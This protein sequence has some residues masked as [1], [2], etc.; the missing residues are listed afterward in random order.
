MAVGSGSQKQ[1]F[2]MALM[3]PPITSPGSVV[4]GVRWCQRGSVLFEPEDVGQEPY[5]AFVPS[6]ESCLVV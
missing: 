5:G 4:V 1:L 2:P 6:T 3:A